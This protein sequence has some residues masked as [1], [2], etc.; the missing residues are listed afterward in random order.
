MTGAI[1]QLAVSRG[2]VPKRAVATAEVTWLGLVGDVQRH[3]KFHGGP[4]RA[5]CLYALE[6]IERLR[7]AGHPIAPGTT[8]ENVTIRGI[9][10]ATLGPGVRL[11][12]GD[13]VIVELT[14]P[15]VPCKQIADSFSDRKFVRIA[16]LGEARLYARVVR[17]GRL[18]AGDRVV[19][20]P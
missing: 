19:R 11:A 5:L 16:A 3:T 1:V 8:G 2:G 4:E 17:E 15:A 9:D 7:A 18:C 13:Q 20:D 6:V 10:W 12:L 14:T